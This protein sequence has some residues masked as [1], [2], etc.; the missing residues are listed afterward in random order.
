[1]KKPRRPVVRYHGGKWMMAKTII[2]HF[3]Q[4]RIYVEPLGGASV[5]LQKPR[6]YSEVYND[7][8]ADIV[9][10]FRVL[11]D[12]AKAARLRELV[13]LTPFARTEYDA[14]INRDGDDIEWARGSIYRSFAGFGAGSINDGYNTG[15]RAS[16]NRSGTT[17]A[18]DWMNWPK[19][20]PAFTERLRGVV[21][22]NRPAL[23]VITQHDTTATLHYLDPPYVH[24]TRNATKTN[25]YHSEMTDQQHIDLLACASSLKGMVAISGYKTDLYMD[26][27]GHWKMVEFGAM[28][29]GAKKRTECLWMNFDQIPTLF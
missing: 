25:V 16:S 27:I 1:M 26:L 17:P 9:N 5:L 3:P 14:P 29:D 8:F 12:P 13:E 22:E 6:S 4:H 2:Q 7:L 11:R 24:E 19:N 10:V 15:F 28:A 21:I 20:I 23:D 18:H